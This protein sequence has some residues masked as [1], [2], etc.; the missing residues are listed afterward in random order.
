MG[1][2]EHAGR[3]V[4]SPALGP[5]ALARRPEASEASSTDFVVESL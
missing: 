2:G 3:A 4:L 1:A 5:G